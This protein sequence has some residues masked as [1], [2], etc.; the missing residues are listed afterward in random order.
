MSF[1]NGFE[2][3]FLILHHVPNNLLTPSDINTWTTN[4]SFDS[5]C[6]LDFA[7]V[8]NL[9]APTELAQCL[10]HGSS[11]DKHWACQI[12]LCWRR[13]F[14][15]RSECLASC[16]CITGGHPDHQ[17]HCL[18][19]LNWLQAELCEITK[20]CETCQRVTAFCGNKKG[21]RARTGADNIYWKFVW[22][23]SWLS[24]FFFSVWMH[25]IFHQNLAYFL[26]LRR[27]ECVTKYSFSN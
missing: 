3:P 9:D 24:L 25:L 10:T 17:V 16:I 6:W 2:I 22:Q 19:R 23:L 15:D 8:L 5:G 1:W 14:Y 27:C 18:F 13:N 20:L 4:S 12:L 26:Y 11:E 21:V 7:L